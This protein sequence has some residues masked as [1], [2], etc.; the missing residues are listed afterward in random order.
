M[1]RE[2]V[3]ELLP[4]KLK[5]I[6]LG[7]ENSILRGEY[8]FNNSVVAVYYIDYSTKDLNS[9]I[10]NYLEN[11]ISSDYYNN[12]GYLQ[13]NYYLIFLRN[14]QN[15]D[16]EIKNDI[17]KNDTYA[18]K[19]VFS[20]EE[21]K[22]YFEYKKSDL[23]VDVDII[24]IWKE[25]L[26]GVNLNEI[27]ANTPY[28]EAVPRFISNNVLKEQISETTTTLNAE[29]FII[30]KLS[31]LKFADEYRPYPKQRSFLFGKSNLIK[32]V[33]GSGKTSLLEGIELIITGKNY[34][35][36]A[37]IEPNNCITSIYNNNPK[38]S[39]FYVPGD[40]TKYRNR[41]ILWYASGYKSGNELYRAF[42]KYNF[43]DSDAAFHLSY[44]SDIKSLSKYLSS[45]A[46]GS[47]FIR[48]QDRLKGFNERLSKE[49]RDRN[50]IISEETENKRKAQQSLSLV[51][52]A[53]TPASNFKLFVEFSKEI[54]WI[55]E[56][57]KNIDDK[58]DSFESDY[59]T[60]QSNSN[61]LIQ[62]ISVV[63]LVD[64]KTWKLELKRIEESISNY[65]KCRQEIE[66]LNVGIKERQSALKEDSFK[67]SILVQAESFYLNSDS[68]QLL[69]LD[70]KISALASNISKLQRVLK[71]IEDIMGNEIFS[72]DEIFSIYKATSLDLNSSLKNEAKR[73]KDQIEALKAN[74][75]KLDT[76]IT[77]IKSYG[78]QYILLNS[79]AD[80]CPLCETHYS[81]EELSHRISEI[82]DKI[83]ENAA[84]D[85]LN[86]QLL[87]VT[88]QL[89]QSDLLIST[90]E[91]IEKGISILQ[92]TK[93][94]QLK[95]SEIKLE[96]DLAKASLEFDKE[97]LLKLSAL[98][99]SLEEKGVSESQFNIIKNNVE[100]HFPDLEFAY[101]SKDIFIQLLK[102]TR[103]GVE[104]SNKL[105]V[106]ETEEIEKI[107]VNYLESLKE[108]LNDASFESLELELDFKKNTLE[109]G[110]NYFNSISA[111]ISYSEIDNI[112]DIQQNV[113]KLNAHFEK[114]K[115]SLSEQRELV[116][117]NQILNQANTK[118]NDLEPE[119][120]IL[121][122][123]LVVINDLL[124]NYSETKILGEFI[125]NNEGQIQEIF[126]NIHSPKEFSK[127]VF[128][129][130]SNTVVL[131]RKVSDQDV[132]L[133]KIS[134]GQRSALALSIFIALN[135]KLKNGPNMIIF[136]DPVTYTDDLNIL[137]FLDYLREIIIHEG[138]QLI[139][140]TANL[141]LASLFEK[142]FAFLGDS[143]FRIFTLERKNL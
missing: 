74:L 108:I 124:T 77:E 48:I 73:L 112:N 22:N 36:P 12:P 105:N 1:N 117:A 100:T 103:T 142:K 126:E 35:D 113:N 70:V 129:Y 71:L 38:H 57:P 66:K 62:L 34:K 54:K 119:I 49:L 111:L 52:S 28:S 101:N 17:E 4:D 128:N 89:E 121:N 137:S 104:D 68:F 88:G 115:K 106:I 39:D 26:N 11:H 107:K 99:I 82:S 45:I 7:E 93:Y 127:I 85:I 83:Q 139:F 64:L 109:K 91:T 16:K 18:R 25:K 80:S 5:N 81:F 75:N 21:L 125:N 29:S 96:F 27:Y 24:S 37:S 10:S 14:E 122:S 61:S 6:Q 31:S 114:Y 55:G 63:K 92:P 32:G 3:L 56:L 46:L 9:N 79:G 131:K 59:L 51:Q 69:G 15:I 58:A 102:K 72:N 20:S 40:N 19:F 33:N 120:I 30:D 90:I 84:I 50:K 123:G 65:K 60:F 140:A 130:S 141:K 138:R 23:K 143:E 116:L 53:S 86:G 44:D 95:L 2:S 87:V 41:D 94:A 136:D 78:K 97:E 118:L 135:K 43:Y 133:T 76:I 13:W 67:L 132:P 8:I 134:S 110:I 98:K 47:E 42:N